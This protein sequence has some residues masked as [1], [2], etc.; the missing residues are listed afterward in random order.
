[1][2]PWTGTVLVRTIRSDNPLGFGGVILFGHHVDERGVKLS[3]LGV[4]VKVPWN[5]LYGCKPA[6]FEFWEVSGEA[7][8]ENSKGDGWERTET[9]VETTSLMMTR[10]SG[11]ILVEI[12]AHGNRF[13]GIGT[14]KAQDLWSRFGEGLYDILDNGDVAT[15]KEVL[16][17]DAAIQLA[18]SWDNYAEG[19]FISYLQKHGFP[20]MMARKFL[21]FHGKKSKEMLEDDPYRLISYCGSW[22]KV[23]MLAKKIFGLALDDPRRLSGSVQE[24]LCS[25]IGDQDTASSLEKLKQKLRR[26]LVVNGDKAETSRLVEAA[27][28]LAEI[29]GSYLVTP[30]GLYQTVGPYIM[31][32]FVASRISEYV[33]ESDPQMSLFMF[34]VTAGTIDAHIDEFEG[35]SCVF[36]LTNEQRAAVH[37]SVNARFSIITGGAGTGKTT[38]LKCLY[39]VLKN[40]GYGVVQMALAGKA[41]KRMREATGKES[42]TIAG[43]LKNSEKLQEAHGAH[44]YYVVDEASMLDLKTAYRIFQSLPNS[45][46]MVMVGDAFQLPPIGAGLIFHKLVDT[47]VVPKTFLSEVKRQEGSTGIPHFAAEIR[48]GVWPIIKAPGIKV[49]PCSNQEIMPQVLGL[50]LQDPDRSQILCAVHRNPTSGVDAINDAC[51]K[52]SNSNGRP[53]RVLGINGLP[54]PTRFR[55]GDRII[56]TRN[57]WNRGV[58]NGSMGIITEAL[59]ATENFGGEEDPVVGMALV[60]GVEQPI[61]LSDVYYGDPRLDL[62]Y[63]VTCHKAQGSQFH[64]VIIP[65]HRQINSEGKLSSRIIDLTWVYTALTR[66]ECEVIFVGCQETIQKAVEGGPRWHQRVVGFGD[67]L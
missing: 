38:V 7:S 49:V 63:A 54:S 39:H 66:A 30:E 25:I 6:P 62:G 51:Q 37:T 5:L 2:T 26:L 36:P 43:F 34:G 33:G 35:E 46:R 47:P 61:L 64:R 41:A 32:A 60:D 31:E 16:T 29:N 9:V 13:A 55:K 3:S 22:A 21:D 40:L 15:L 11:G 65:V 67:R 4:Q 50:F 10:H 8:V 14:R 18:E 12:L 57:D 53:I 1:M 42:H 45:V 58:M 28:S 27:V 23:D 24:A 48:K 52:V 19:R 59:D 44:T 56:F 17:Q 20:A